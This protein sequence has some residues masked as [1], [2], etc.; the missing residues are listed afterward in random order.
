MGKP[1]LYQ[2]LAS[3]SAARGA[4]QRSP[5][6]PATRTP[7]CFQMRESAC[8]AGLW[9]LG[10][11]V[12]VHFVPLPSEPS[13]GAEQRPEEGQGPRTLDQ[14]SWRSLHR[15]HDPNLALQ[16]G[17]GAP[18][19]HSKPPSP[20]SFLSWVLLGSWV[21]KL[22]LLFPPSVSLTGSPEAG[23]GRVTEP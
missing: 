1:S 18:R 13:P 12:P 11:L 22:C 3:P 20:D 8:L 7:H 14:H 17:S 4:G 21:Q 2:A 10:H 19:L 5:Q 9:Q 16:M 6:V 15:A 23:E